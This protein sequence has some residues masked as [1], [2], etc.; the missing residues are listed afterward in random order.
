MLL[1][2]PIDSGLGHKAALGVR[3]V[4][5]ELPGRQV[6]LLKGQ[7]D[8]RRPDLLRDLIPDPSRS[9]LAVL[10]SLAPP[11]RVPPIPAVERRPR[12][13]DRRQCAT[14]R[15]RRLFHQFDDLELLGCRVPHEVSSPS[16]STL[17]LSRRFSIKTSA[18][19]SLSWRASALSS[20]TSPEVASRAVS[21]AS[22]FLPASATIA[23]RLGRD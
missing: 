2:E 5:G 15:E 14:D 3:E 23:G 11:P 22:R 13:P 4:D 10:Q 9:G 8:D 7:I 17:F 6:R 20:L 16:P 19:V 1:Q 12:D 18:S 21:P